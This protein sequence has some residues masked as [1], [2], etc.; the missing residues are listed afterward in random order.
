MLARYWHVIGMLQH[1]KYFF[2]DSDDASSKFK[3][4][5]AVLMILLFVLFQA[6]IIYIM[7]SS[8]IGSWYKRSL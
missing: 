2:L 8:S 6:V 7:F 4:A 3:L 1:V 5:P